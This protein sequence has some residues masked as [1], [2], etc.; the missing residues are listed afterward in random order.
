MLNMPPS[1]NA[2]IAQ[3]LSW[4]EAELI[5]LGVSTPRLDAE[6][7]LAHSLGTNRAGL[8]ARLHADLSLT[9]ITAFQQRV[10]RRLQGEPVQYIT[11]VQEFWSLE[12]AVDQRVLIPRPETELVVETALRLLFPVPG[13]LPLAPCRILDVGTGSGCLAIALATE[14]PATE[15]WATDISSDAL[16][17]AATNAHR[18]NVH[19]RVRFLQGDLFAPVADQGYIFDLIVSNPPYIARHDLLTLQPEV[20]DWEPRYALDGGEDGLNFYRHLLA[21]APRYLSTNGWLV[22]EIGDGQDT[23]LLSSLEEN[24]SFIDSFCIPDYTGRGRV[25]AAQKN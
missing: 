11:G 15:I 2:T 17:V 13:P 5:L 7:L 14:L 6:V 3:I 24:T 8:Y 12:F 10:Y 22:L 25:V 4:A 23:E 21:E 19:Q 16:A 9:Q 1:A 20:R 18:H